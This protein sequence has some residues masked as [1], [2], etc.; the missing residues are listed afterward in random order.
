ML[1]NTVFSLANGSA[2][3]ALAFFGFAIFTIGFFLWVA[4]LARRK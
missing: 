2:S 3:Q 4:D 1:E